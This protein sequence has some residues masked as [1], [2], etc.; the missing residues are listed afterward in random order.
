EGG[1]KRRVKAFALAIAGAA[2]ASIVVIWAVYGFRYSTVPD[3]E[4]ARAE[5]IAARATL[6]QRVLDAPDVWPTGHL[7]VAFAVQRWAAMERLAKAMPEGAGQQDMRVA[8]RTTRPTPT[9][10]LILFAAAHHML[11][12]AY[13]YGFAST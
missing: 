4:A 2:I 6:R 1:A 8:I 10:R 12:E 3:P 11:P 13:L 5:E 7:D 9:G